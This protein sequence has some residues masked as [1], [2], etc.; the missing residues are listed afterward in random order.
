[1]TK[2]LNLRKLQQVAALAMRNG[3]RLHFES[4]TMYDSESYGTALFLSVIAMEEIGKAFWSDHVAWTT[5]MHRDNPRDTPME[6][7]RIVT[8]F[9]DHR[10][11][12]LAFL[13]HLWPTLST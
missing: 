9:S 7:K 3:I 2:N 5:M 11:K 13:R 6:Q 4:I 8:L 12:Q 1:M 10:R